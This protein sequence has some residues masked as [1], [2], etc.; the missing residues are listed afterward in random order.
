MFVT[1]IIFFFFFVWHF[2]KL[3]Y[4][5]HLNQPILPISTCFY[6]FLVI[7]LI[8]LLISTYFYLFLPLPG[9]SPGANSCIWVVCFEKYST[10]VKTPHLAK[11]FVQKNPIEISMFGG[12][13]LRKH[14]TQG[15]PLT[16]FLTE[17]LV[18]VAFSANNNILLLNHF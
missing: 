8:F 6:L 15:Y 11:L 9:I 10:F 18:N 17:S 13:K 12:L 1:F 4:L 2:L 3:C 16:S 7:W 5:P 14:Q